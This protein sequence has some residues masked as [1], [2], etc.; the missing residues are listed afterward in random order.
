MPN[1]EALNQPLAINL[2]GGFF[3][4]KSLN[5]C[6]VWNM[7]VKSLRKYSR[8]KRVYGNNFSKD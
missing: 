4:S 6:F 1:G 5:K 3:T 7:F 2:A 8:V